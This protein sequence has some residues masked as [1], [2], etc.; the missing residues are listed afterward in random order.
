MK[1]KVERRVHI[2]LAFLVR[3]LV[4]TDSRGNIIYAYAPIT[5]TLANLNI[6]HAHVINNQ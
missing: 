6:L 1:N 4:T 3:G 2:L 5:S